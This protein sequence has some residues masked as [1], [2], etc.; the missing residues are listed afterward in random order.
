MSTT[1][2]RI[3]PVEALHVLRLARR[4]VGEVDA[5]HRAGLRDRDVHL[6]EIERVP[7]GILERRGLEGLEEDAA[8]VGAQDGGELP[9]ALDA[10][11]GDLHAG[12]AISTTGRAWARPEPPPIGSPQREFI[13]SSPWRRRAVTRCSTT[14]RVARRRPRHHASPHRYG[15][16]PCHCCG[17]RWRGHRCRRSRC[18][19]D[20]C[21]H[22]LPEVGE[23]GADVVA[24][25]GVAARHARGGW[26][27]FAQPPR[28]APDR[29]CRNPGPDPVRDPVDACASMMTRSGGHRLPSAGAGASC[30]PTRPGTRS[31]GSSWTVRAFVLHPS[32]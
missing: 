31:L 21:R 12:E 9:H 16:R 10:A 7:D 19:V 6:L 13:V 27:A 8:V 17:A 28:P 1:T 4:H 15:H 2:S 3:R 22:R 18:D 29:G 26:S 24:V 20:P 30:A 25:D 14:V 32:P 23:H 11:R 5:A